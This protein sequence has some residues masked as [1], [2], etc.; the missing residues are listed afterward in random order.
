MSF[1]NSEQSLIYTKGLSSFEQPK[2]A[3]SMSQQICQKKDRG[4]TEK[5]SRQDTRIHVPWDE[6]T[7]LLMLLVYG[8]GSL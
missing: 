7:E 5:M 6:S 2:R 4:K 8:L 1:N 3:C